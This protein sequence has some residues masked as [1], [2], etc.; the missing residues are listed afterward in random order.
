MVITF[1]VSKSDAI[2]LERFL[3]R[4]GWTVSKLGTAETELDR[5]RE[6]ANDGVARIITA[7][8]R[9]SGESIPRLITRHRRLGSRVILILPTDI[10]ANESSA[11]S[12]MMRAGADDFVT[13]PNVDQE[14]ALRL[15]VIDCRSAGG[16]QFVTR[17]FFGLVLDG[18]GRRLRNGKATVSLTP[19]EFRLLS[20]LARHPGRVV[21]RAT[22]HA[23]MARQGRAVTTNLVHVYILYLRRKLARLNSQCVV[24]TVRGVGYMLSQRGDA[25]IPRAVAHVREEDQWFFIS[26]LNS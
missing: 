20:C 13:A 11:L 24:R 2:P 12:R 18:E 19:S 14:L 15:A 1:I 7:N 17:S 26:T 23:C 16:K 5:A 6:A 25:S 9:E 8:F 3:D 10:D 22:L 21:P 4:A